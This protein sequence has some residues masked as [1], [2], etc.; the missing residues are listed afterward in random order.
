MFA[1]GA[2]RLLWR[3]GAPLLRCWR[4][5]CHCGPCHGLLTRS[6]LVDHSPRALVH[7]VYCWK[8]LGVDLAHGTAPLCVGRRGVH[9]VPV[10]ALISAALAS[11]HLSCTGGLRDGLVCLSF[12]CLSWQ[13]RTSWGKFKSW[14]SPVRHLPVNVCMGGC[15]ILTCFVS[16]TPFPLVAEATGSQRDFTWRDAYCVL[17]IAEHSPRHRTLPPWTARSWR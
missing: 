8:A 11:R 14:T 12:F 3:T 15:S 10:L 17:V 6:S 1:D 5:P 16:L 7:C 9:P 4:W 2:A 13:W